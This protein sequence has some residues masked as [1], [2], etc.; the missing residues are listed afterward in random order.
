VDASMIPARS[1]LFVPSTRPERFAK[2]AASGADRVILDLEDA[3]SPSEKAEARRNLAHAVLPRDV[4]LYVRVN[5]AL[6]PWFEDD[7]ALAATLDVHG[8]LLPKADSAAHV[9][10][11]AT[12]V[13]RDRAIVP[14][15]ETALGFWNVLE[16]ARASRVER[17]V[18]GGLD[19]SLDTGMRDEEGVFDHVRSRIVIASRVAGI[20]PPV[21]YVTLAIDDQDLLARHAARSRRFGF[22]GKLCIHP[23]QLPATN[24][25]FRPRDEELEWARAVLAEQAA[26]PQDA[27]F[28]HRGELVDRPVVE[29]ARQIAAAAEDARRADAPRTL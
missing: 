6:T 20:A 28:A 10:R 7:L 4:P 26:R 22:G 23:K 24:A 8:I 27:V 13:G 9:E 1:W 18:F 14:I 11:A 15:I 2:A 3:V 29:R 16:V 5:S 21:D 12:A 17:L 19:F 25:A